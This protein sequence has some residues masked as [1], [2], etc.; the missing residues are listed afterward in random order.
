VPGDSAFAG[1][2]DGNGVDEVGLHRVS[3]GRVYYRLSLT[4]GVAD[5]DF[6]Y[7]NPGDVVF[8]GD[9][10]GNGTDTVGLYRPGD[11]NWYLRLSNTQG[12]ADHGVPFGLALPIQ[13]RPFVGRSNISIA[14]LAN[15]GCVDCAPIGG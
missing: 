7:G 8:A 14:G 13:V 15:L 9:W 10:D 3:S 6:I 2:F 4:Q 12:A 1:D 11:G 5:A